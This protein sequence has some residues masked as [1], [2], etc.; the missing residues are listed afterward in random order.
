[1]EQQWLIANDQDGGLRAMGQVRSSARD[2]DG[3]RAV[4]GETLDGEPATAIKAAA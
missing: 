2:G 4:A 3:R 1:M